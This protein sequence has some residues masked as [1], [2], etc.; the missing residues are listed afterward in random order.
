MRAEAQNTVEAIEK[1]LE[2]LGQRL[3]L[4]TVEHRIEEFNAR[5]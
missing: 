1:S 5:V 3:D 2:L 4:E